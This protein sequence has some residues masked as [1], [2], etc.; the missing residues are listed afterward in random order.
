MNPDR[1]IHR[2]AVAVDQGR[3]AR[4]FGRTDAF[5]V[6]RSN[7]TPCPRAVYR[8]RTSGP[9]GSESL[10]ER[11]HE[12]V[13]ALLDDC[14]TVIC[15]GIGDHAAAILEQHGIQVVV[16]AADGFPEEIYQRFT[17]GTLANGKVHPCCHS[18]D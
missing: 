14:E 6:F 2:T 3:L 18:H 12:E 1:S 4:H 16:T 11:H 5:A 10:H 9:P 15:G 8:V 13:A 7:P 17:K